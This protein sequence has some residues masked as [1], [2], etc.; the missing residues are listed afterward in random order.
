MFQ[1]WLVKMA[2]I[3]ANSAPKTRPGASDMKNTTVIEMKPKIGTDW[4]MSRMGTNSLPARSLLAAQVAYVRVNSNDSARAANMRNVVRAAYSGKRAGSNDI[5]VNSSAVSGA[6]SP[7]EV[8]PKNT[9]N[10]MTTMKASTSQRVASS[11]KNTGVSKKRFIG[12]FSQDS[13]RTS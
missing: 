13:R 10:P 3:A 4:R 7:R 1:A 6:N 8:S 2:K 11:R 5:G 12:A 9:T